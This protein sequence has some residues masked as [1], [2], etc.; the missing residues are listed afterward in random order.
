[1]S[2]FAMF[3]VNV[4]EFRKHL[5]EYLKKIQQGEEIQITNRGKVIARVV[6]EVDE[7]EAARQR[8]L[9]LRGKGHLLLFG[10]QAPEAYLRD[11]VIGLELE[12]LTITP[13]IAVIAQSDIF[14]RKDPADRLIAAT[15]IYHH[16]GLISADHQLRSIPKLRAIW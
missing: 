7:A 8:L 13:E 2:G 6:P 11:L 9:A 5:P 3:A 16:A 4:T 10:T 15:A 1:M 12:V 14:T